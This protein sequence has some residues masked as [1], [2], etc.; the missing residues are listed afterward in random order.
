VIV[1]VVVLDILISGVGFFSFGRL[2]IDVVFSRAFTWDDCIMVCGVS[3]GVMRGGGFCAFVGGFL[4][5]L[6]VVVLFS[7]MYGVK[8]AK[9]CGVDEV[10]SEG[11]TFF[12]RDM[13]V[14]EY[15]LVVG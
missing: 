4:V 11:F 9:M 7:F 12:L 14:G 8:R 2:V 3:V 15:F 5:V 10:F 13:F 1:N 6:W